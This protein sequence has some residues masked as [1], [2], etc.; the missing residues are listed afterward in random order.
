M[1]STLNGPS[2]RRRGPSGGA[3]P[4]HLARRQAE[5]VNRRDLE[6]LVSLYAEDAVLEFPA[7][8]AITGKSAIRRAF[9]R[10]FQDW[11]EEITLHRLVAS[12][13]V[14]AAEGTAQGRHRTL[15]SQRAYRH[16]FAAFW[17]IHRGKIR[18]HRVYYDARELVR[19]VLGA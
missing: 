19:Q 3:G 5:A 1:S 2:R 17:E 11:D 12:G 8:P 7:S 6:G 15:I 10:F 18:R 4:A 9:E 14:V 16:A 13:R